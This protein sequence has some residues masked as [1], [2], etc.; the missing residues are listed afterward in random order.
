MT[1]DAPRAISAR[2]VDSVRLIDGGLA[3]A[4]EVTTPDD[5]P[6]AVLL[7]KQLAADLRDTLTELLSH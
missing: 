5:K 3:V 1:E 2:S 6:F 7:T 4:I